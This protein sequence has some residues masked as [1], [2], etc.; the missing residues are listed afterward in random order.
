MTEKHCNECQ[1]FRLRY[2]KER[3]IY[4]ECKHFE[5]DVEF[6]GKICNKFTTEKDIF[7]IW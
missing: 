3:G 4:Y 6:N 2:S 1:Y 5:S 7:N